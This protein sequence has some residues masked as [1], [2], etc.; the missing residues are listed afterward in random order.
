MIALDV[1]C[2]QGKAPLQ[3]KHLHYAKQHPQVEENVRR[4]S[5]NAANAERTSLSQLDERDVCLITFPMQHPPSKS[6][7]CYLQDILT[8]C[9]VVIEKIRNVSQL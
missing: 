6:E 4:I 8:Q 3:R 5:A 2:S 7:G 1:S 9:I